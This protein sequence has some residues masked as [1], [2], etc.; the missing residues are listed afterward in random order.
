MSTKQQLQELAHLRLQ[1]AEVLFAADLYDGCVYLCGYVIELALK[2]C[3]CAKLG[4]QEY[5]GDSGT[6]DRWRKDTFWIQDFDDLSLLAGLESEISLANPALLQ[7]WS[8]TTK[9]RPERRY[10]AKG[11]YKEVD[12]VK[13]LDAIRAKPDGVL[14]WLSKHW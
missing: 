4:V 12:A 1:E 8:I 10:Q 3:V 14:E 5:P 6:R 9:W 13:I 11:T 2:A 7:N